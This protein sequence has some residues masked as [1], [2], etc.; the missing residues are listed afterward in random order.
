MHR[1]HDHHTITI[2]LIL[3]LLATHPMVAEA[4]DPAVSVP[5][6]PPQSQSI[7]IGEWFSR[8][9]QIRRDA[10]L[11]LGEKL[12]CRG[13]LERGMQGEIK[14]GGRSAALAEKMIAKYGAA[15]S[16]MQDLPTV[17]QTSELQSGYAQYFNQVHQL[18]QDCLKSPEATA[19]TGQ[20]LPERRKELEE[21]DKKNKSLDEVLRKEF[22]IP[23]H[24]HI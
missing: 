21:L 18:F 8:Y 4:L 14:P 16:R 7:D 13:L 20:A 12:Q 11:T 1:P 23:R 24:K 19:V 3:A 2:A 5:A 9:D 6:D 22:G 10:E 15:A 17:M